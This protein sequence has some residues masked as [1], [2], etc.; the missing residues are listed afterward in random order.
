MSYQTAEPILEGEEHEERGVKR[1]APDAVEKNQLQKEEKG[2]AHEGAE[3][4]ADVKVPKYEWRLTTPEDW[5]LVQRVYDKKFSRGSASPKRVKE[6]PLE[7]R[8]K[9][10]ADDG[11]SQEIQLRV[12]TVANDEVLDC[13]TFYFKI[14]SSSGV[15]E[16]LQQMSK[17]ASVNFDAQELE[18]NLT[19]HQR[20]GLDLKP[21][22]NLGAENKALVDLLTCLLYIHIGESSTDAWVYFDPEDG[23]RTLDVFFVTCV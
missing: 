19:A 21:E 8:I 22:I 23:L 1:P 4:G 12:S 7:E 18:C 10:A 20:P 14:T 5:E 11:P 15:I 9:G 6:A 17:F 3:F 2:G 16:Q 13:R